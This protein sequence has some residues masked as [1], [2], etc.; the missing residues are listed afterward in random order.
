[1]IYSRWD[2]SGGY[3]DYFEGDERPGINDDL[4]EPNLPRGTE[5]GVPSTDCGR[6]VPDG[7]A[8]LGSGEWA[9]GIG[10]G[11]VIAKWKPK[12]RAA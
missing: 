7:A 3:Y 2:P 4:P 11:Y 6:P 5:I 9:V 12:Q 1:V 8:Y 10:L